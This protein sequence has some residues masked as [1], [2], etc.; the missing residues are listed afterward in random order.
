MLLEE[1]INQMHNKSKGYKVLININGK[2]QLVSPSDIIID[3]DYTLGDLLSD[4]SQLK[5]DNT[6]YK[7]TVDKLVKS[8][9]A[10]C[11]VGKFMKGKIK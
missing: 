1:K 2:Q 9:N 11:D 3:V 7:A 10:I 5:K 8:N 6:K 4:V